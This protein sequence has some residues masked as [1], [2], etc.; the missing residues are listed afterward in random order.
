ML[1]KVTKFLKLVF[2]VKSFK[3]F[4]KLIEIN[5]LDALSNSS[6]ASC[7]ARSCARLAES[8]SSIVLTNFKGSPTFLNL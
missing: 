8:A 4:S 1:T 3:I 6:A 5:P 7:V 2:Q